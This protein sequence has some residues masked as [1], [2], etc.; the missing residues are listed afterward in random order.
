[1]LASYVGDDDEG[2]AL[3][4]S[5]RAAGCD[6]RHVRPRP[7]AYSDSGVIV[8]SGQPPQRDR[9]IFWVQGTKPIMGDHLPIDELLAREWL[10]ID[11]DDPRLRAFML[12]LPSHRSPRTLLLGTMTYLVE[13]AQDDGWQH[14]LRHDAMFGNERELRLLT[15]AA[16]FDEALA[17]AQH[18]MIGQA[19][20]VMYISRGASGSVAI[21]TNSV[22]AAAAYPVDVV[23]TTGAGDAFAAGCIWGLVDRATDDEVLRRGNAVGGLACRALGARAGLPTRA[24]ALDL[25]AMGKPE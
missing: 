7:G 11:V 6:V 22:T 2:R 9:T 21:R 12:D 16:S 15:E 24:E 18:D 13:M 5:L 20:R 8:V 19:C 17:R 10:L 14:A 25:I 4:E 23:D 1:M 3:I